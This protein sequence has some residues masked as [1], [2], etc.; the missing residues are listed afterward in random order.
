MKK[1]WT[2]LIEGINDDP[3]K[4]PYDYNPGVNRHPKLAVI[5]VIFTILALIIIGLV[6]WIDNYIRYNF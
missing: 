1:W 2:R 4:G 6:I 5:G 3:S